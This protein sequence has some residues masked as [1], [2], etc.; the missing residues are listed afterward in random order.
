MPADWQTRARTLTS[1]LA[2]GVEVILPDLNDIALAKLDAWRAMDIDWLEAA[3]RN[4]LLDHAAMAGRIDR[5]E[6]E[7]PI[8]ELQPRTAQWPGSGRQ[9]RC[10]RNERK[11]D[12]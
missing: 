2:P 7:L 5:I 4:G 9:R 6:C 12:G 3:L 1:A 8:G 11:K 10:G